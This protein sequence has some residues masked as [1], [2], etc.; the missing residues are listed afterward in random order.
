MFWHQIHDPLLFTAQNSPTESDH[1]RSV[2][3]A[4]L[5]RLEDHTMSAVNNQSLSTPVTVIS[6]NIEGLTA[7]KASI[8]SESVVTACAPK[9]HT[10][11]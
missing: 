7:S 5:A 9:K 2:L 6:A 4:I 1:G 8:L 10:N 3:V 11:L